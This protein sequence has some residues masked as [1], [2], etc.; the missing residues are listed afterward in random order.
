MPDGLLKRPRIALFNVNFIM[1]VLQAT[2]YSNTIVSAL[3]SF[4]I[5]IVVLMYCY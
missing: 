4:G 5:R 3:L 1:A 2:E